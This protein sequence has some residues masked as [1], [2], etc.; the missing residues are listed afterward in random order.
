MAGWRAVE[1]RPG[2]NDPETPAKGWRVRNNIFPDGLWRP[3]L[4]L[5]CHGETHLNSS[6]IPFY[7]RLTLFLRMCCRAPTHA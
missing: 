3:L 2:L 7:L 1:P 6:E 4:A 5:A